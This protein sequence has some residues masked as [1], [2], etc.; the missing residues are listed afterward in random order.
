MIF[1]GKGSWL[2]LLLE[3]IGEL[4]F[5]FI[6]GVEIIDVLNIGEKFFI[7]RNLKELE[8]LLYVFFRKKKNFLN[9]KKV[10]RVLGMD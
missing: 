5:V 4:V 10:M 1:F 7:F 8:I 9:V 2:Y 6:V 3:F